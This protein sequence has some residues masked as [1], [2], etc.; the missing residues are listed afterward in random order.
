MWL[1]TG[2]NR[3]TKMLKK[4]RD[5]LRRGMLMWR[6]AQLLYFNMRKSKVIPPR[7]EGNFVDLRPHQGS[8]SFHLARILKASRVALV[9]VLFLSLT[10]QHALAATCKKE[11]ET[12]VSSGTKYICVAVGSKTVWKAKKVGTPLKPNFL[13]VVHEV[14]LDVDD[15]VLAL[16]RSEINRLTSRLGQDANLYIEIYDARSSTVSKKALSSMTSRNLF[17]RISVPGNEGKSLR[18]AAGKFSFDEIRNRWEIPDQAWSS[19]QTLSKEAIRKGILFEEDS[20]RSKGYKSVMLSESAPPP[21]GWIKTRPECS[22]RVCPNRDGEP[23]AIAIL[24]LRS[25]DQQEFYSTTLAK[26]IQF[27]LKSPSGKVSV[28]MRLDVPVGYDNLLYTTNEVGI[29]EARISAIDSKGQSRWSDPIN[30]SIE[31]LSVVGSWDPKLPRCSTELEAAMKDG[32]E[33]YGTLME[34]IDEAWDS[35]AEVKTKY[36][37]AALFRNIYEAQQYL[38]ILQDWDSFLA[39]SYARAKSLKETM[40]STRKTCN[41]AIALDGYV[42]PRR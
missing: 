15:A 19:P 25:A 31:V 39:G 4:N 13:P 2:S 12:K 38:R 26:Q 11:G 9:C 24:Q 20:D 1:G 10:P 23:G 6:F 28:T 40:D 18:I 7:N 34:N 29:W 14:L 21:M 8:N 36:E 35:G 22:R 30:F 27:R 5:E 33:A 42:E 37:Y 32:A 17:P 41:S 16:S 3:R